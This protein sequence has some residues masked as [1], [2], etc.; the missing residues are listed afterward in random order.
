MLPDWAPNAHPLIVHFPIAL[1]FAAVLVDAVLLVM[2]K[3]DAMSAVL[4]VLAGVGALAAFLS[5]RAAIDSL[6][7]PPHVVPDSNAHADWGLRAVWVLGLY[8]VLRVVTW[9][10][11]QTW[12]APVRIPLFL[13]SLI[14]LYVVW[15]TAEH[16]GRLVFQ[17]GL[18]TA[19]EAAGMVEAPAPVAAGEPLTGAWAWTPE[20]GLGSLLQGALVNPLTARAR[21]EFVD[22][23][24]VL[25]VDGPA[26]ILIADTTLGV[27]FDARINASQVEGSVF[28]VH[29][30]TDA[31]NFH[32]LRLGSDLSASQG[33]RI[34]GTDSRMSTGRYP[35]SDWHT[36]RVV[37]ETTHYRAYVNGALVTHGHG[38]AAPAGRV[39]IHVEGGTVYISELAS[40][41]IG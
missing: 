35:S 4:F 8:G 39:G 16:G 29:N 14:G 31:D 20:T 40:T 24:S 9:R 30:A 12:R 19:V 38:D 33:S 22:G 13:V 27:Q 3:S 10:L 18:G 6:M 17:H 36:V 21:I 1:F 23:Q 15:E 37:G 34:S 11:V 2:R 7:V 5:G 28:V 32:Y 26:T 41:P 25:A